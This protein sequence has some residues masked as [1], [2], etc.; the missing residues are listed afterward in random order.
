VNEHQHTARFSRRDAIRKLARLPQEVFSQ[1]LP[2][3]VLLLQPPKLVAEEVLPQCA[4]AIAACWQA[5]RGPELSAVEQVLPS[6]LWALE[7]LARDASQPHHRQTAAHLAA[8]G[9]QLA[10][11]LALHRNQ[12]AAREAYGRRS[13]HWA[14]VA[15]DPSLLVAV[16]ATFGA[17]FHYSGQPTLALQTYQEAVPSL[18]QASPLAQSSLLMKQAEAYAQ[19]GLQREAERSLNRAYRLFP[20]HPREDPAFPYADCG[21]PSLCLWDG[22]TYLALSKTQTDDEPVAHRLARR[23]WETLELCGGAHPPFVI[24]KRNHLEI[25][26]HQAET[27][28]LL[29]DLELFTSC[30]TEA[31]TGAK[32]LGSQWRRKEAVSVYW[33]ARHHWPHEDRVKELAELFLW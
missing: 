22:L 23:V 15:D 12:L 2:E 20:P 19:L 33:Q 27:A 17:T 7:Q 26:N 14:R 10:G 4:T 9:H 16:I 21:E 13:L 30:L 6:Y 1:K 24:S 31:V 3:H 29:D 11:I 28:V 8:Q 32:A 25:L 5:S 18:E